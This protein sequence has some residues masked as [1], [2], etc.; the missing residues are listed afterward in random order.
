MTQ[1]KILRNI[2]SNR[3]LWLNT[4]LMP[5][6]L[7]S[8]SSSASSANAAAQNSL[9]SQ[10]SKQHT[11]FLQA[12]IIQQVM[13]AAA[14]STHS[15]R[16]EFSLEIRVQRNLIEVE[17]IMDRNFDI[18]SPSVSQNISQLLFVR[19]SD[20]FAT[21]IPKLHDIINI[22]MHAFPL[23]E[24]TSSRETPSSLSHVLARN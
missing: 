13:A 19:G 4:D 1:C 14:A 18:R 7:P 20:R 2:S 17:T 6:F 11:A 21:L 10:L 9:A 24:Q 15:S 12:Q 8:G 3:I 16:G 22:N 5:G 23:G